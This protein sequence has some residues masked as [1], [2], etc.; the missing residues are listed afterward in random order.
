M[1]DPNGSTCRLATRLTVERATHEP[2]SASVMSAI[3]RCGT[4]IT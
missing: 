1:G 4:P 2:I 3:L